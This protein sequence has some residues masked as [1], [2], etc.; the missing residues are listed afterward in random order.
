MLRSIVFPSI[1]DAI[2]LDPGERVFYAGSK[3]GRI[4]I[5]ALSAE[6]NSSG[7]Y[8]MHIIGSLS[9]HRFV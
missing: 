6:S 2:A 9:D 5:A 4:Y 3:D 1:I 8:G 7:S